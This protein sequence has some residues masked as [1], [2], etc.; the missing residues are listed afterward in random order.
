MTVYDVIALTRADFGASR[1]IE[2]MDATGARFALSAED[3]LLLD[4]VGVEEAVIRRMLEASATPA[5]AVRS[6]QMPSVS[7]LGREPARSVVFG[8]ADTVTAGD[9][10]TADDEAR[11][12]TL[13]G[14]PI[15]VVRERGAYASTALR[16]R[17]LA[18]R[19][20]RLMS[21]GDGRFD[22]RI[23]GTAASV[24]FVTAG[25]EAHPV[26]EATAADASA[27]DRRSVARVTPTLLGRYWAAVLE[28]FIGLAVRG[29]EP[30]RLDDLHQ[31]DAI[32]LLYR[33]MRAVRD[34]DGGT[35]MATASTYLPGP[36]R[37]HLAGL[38]GSVPEDFERLER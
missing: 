31:G 33:G 35:A 38:A 20:T 22:A 37:Q 1:I 2:V 32:V 23:S 34:A 25:G 24:V 27:Y 4:Q 36:V 18:D 12:L 28:D 8:V 14:L 6:T 10:A 5:E 7:P 21:V 26:L 30:R 16:T 15:L 19:L 9:T 29:R 11:V 17:A 13:S 3:V